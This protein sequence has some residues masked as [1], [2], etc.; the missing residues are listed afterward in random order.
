[1]AVQLNP[2]SFG[3][4]VDFFDGQNDIR[5]KRIR[6]LH[7]LS[8][9]EDPTRA[10]RAVRFEQRFQFRIG[11]QDGRLIRNTIELGL[12]DKLSGARILN[13][14]E[15][16]L[17]EKNPLACFLRMQGFDILAAIHPQFDFPPW[18]TELLEKILRSLEWYRHLYLPDQPDP[19]FFFLLAMCRNA[20]VQE[21]RGVLE[22]LALPSSRKD[23]LL[24]ARAAIMDAVP[25][26]EAWHGRNGPA[27]E[28]HAI[29][30]HMPVEGLLYLMARLDQGDL[31]RKLA[32]YIYQGR[33][34]KADIDGRDLRAMG[35]KPGPVYG[36][37][38]QQVLDAKLDGFASGRAAQLALAVEL[39]GEKR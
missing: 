19:L 7:S 6:M 21:L 1:M 16:V 35:L 13:E 2:G 23:A 12:M 17:R 20:P 15:L 11:P 10:L 24:S 4:L 18:K 26:V 25:K 22:R 38:L 5:Q 31:H 34:E 36:R 39:A 14:L 28:L 32:R 37:I 9:V 29:L 27:S 8:F 3:L 30:R 33:R